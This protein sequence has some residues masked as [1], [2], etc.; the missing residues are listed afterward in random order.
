M[1]ACISRERAES[2]PLSAQATQPS[3]LSYPPDTVEISAANKI[4]KTKD[5]MSTGA[6]VVIAALG[7]FGSAVTACILISK[8]QTSK[9]TKLYN[10]KMQLQNLA[11]H[12][13]F[14]KAKTVE[15]GIKF[16]KEVLKVGEVD[17][18]FTLDAIYYANK[19]ITKVSNA[20]KGKLF[21]PKKCIM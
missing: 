18:N 15:E 6:K 14:K 21:I 8:H 1:Y 17:S 4:K 12:I 19:S 9:L 10:E 11:E 20:N 16:V 7:I 5:K 3:Q 13:D 2:N